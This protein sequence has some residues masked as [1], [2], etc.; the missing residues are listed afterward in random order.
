MDS[1]KIKIKA[2]LG[3]DYQ[4]NIE[5]IVELLD[6][7][8]VDIYTTFQQINSNTYWNVACLATSGFDPNYQGITLERL[9][10]SSYLQEG[11]ILLKLG[12]KTHQN[13]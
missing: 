12:S 11:M 1:S 9:T 8:R 13:H 2:I 4:G 3:E 5:V 6:G 7:N 10:R